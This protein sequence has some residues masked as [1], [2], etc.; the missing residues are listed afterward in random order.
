MVVDD[1]EQVVKMMQ[2]M[3]EELNYTVTPINNSATALREFIAQP[4]KFD[5]VITDQT[6]P[7]MTGLQMAGEM[8][9]VRPDLPVILAS[10]FSKMITDKKIKDIGIREYLKKPIVFKDLEQTVR[11]I[12]DNGKNK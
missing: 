7:E 6:M 12:L 4:D 9:R 3:L 5:L 1:E 10:G 8:L 11:R 2:R